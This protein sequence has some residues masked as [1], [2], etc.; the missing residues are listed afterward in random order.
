MTSL[1]QGWSDTGKIVSYT[2]KAENDKQKL[3]LVRNLAV[4]FILLETKYYPA[5]R[6]YFQQI[7]TTDDQQI[8]LEAGAPSASAASLR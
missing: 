5:L 3:H 8:I 7:K 4:D 1:P 2:L 6:E